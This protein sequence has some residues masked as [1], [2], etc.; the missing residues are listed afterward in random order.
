MGLFDKLPEPKLQVVLHRG[1]LNGSAG[2]LAT[3]LR[4]GASDTPANPTLGESYYA[5]KNGAQ[6]ASDFR[7]LIC[8]FYVDVVSAGETAI[9]NDVKVRC[10]LEQ[11]TPIAVPRA[12]F[13]GAVDFTLPAG[14]GHIL[15][16][17]IGISAAAHEVLISQISMEVASG[18]YYPA[19]QLAST[20]NSILALQFAS[21]L[22]GSSS[23]VGSFSWAGTSRTSGASPAVTAWLAKP[24]QNYPSIG[25]T[26]DSIG[27]GSGE[28]GGDG[29]GNYGWI[30]RGLYN[31]GSDNR[32]IPY[33]RISRPGDSF[34]TYTNASG[35]KGT[36][37][38][39][40]LDYVS[41]LFS[42]M[43]TNDAANGT[44]AANIKSRMQFMWQQGKNRGKKVY[45]SLIMPRSSSSDGW[46]TV[47]GQTAD[48]VGFTVG[49]VRDQINAWIPTQVGQGL[50]DGYVDPNPYVET[51]P[52]SNLWI[53]GMTADGV[54][55]TPAGH[56]AASAA[57]RAFAES[58]PNV[59]V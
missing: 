34:N 14:V 5:V 16:E 36:R 18:E 51:A 44:S 12:S 3:G 11:L 30:C 50:L 24:K 33:I 45:Q 55:P 37:R 52:G 57:S 41:Y 8:G 25:I 32:A 56:I 38:L 29:F 54:H 4:G 26:A 20:I 21:T 13:Q 22:S 40:L 19:S 7:A 9:P 48:V 10:A 42:Q 27:D 23:Q 43:G 15:S 28:A 35:N 49:G 6:P 58:L 1:I 46:T 17:P 53:P 39:A 47:N 2:Y 59:L 31:V